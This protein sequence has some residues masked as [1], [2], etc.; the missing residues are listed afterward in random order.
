VYTDNWGDDY[1]FVL[2]IRWDPQASKNNFSVSFEY[3]DEYYE[4]KF[5][6]DVVGNLMDEN[7]QVT[8]LGANIKIWEEY[9]SYYAEGSRDTLLDVDFQYGIR[10]IDSSDVDLDS[11]KGTVS[12]FDL[13]LE[14]LQDM[15][16]AGYTYSFSG[17]TGVL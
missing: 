16:G 14:D 17:G 15:L 10:T 7:D 2:D 3:E 1:N 9:I 11:A 5:G 12:L 8:L 6:V 13:T 4:E